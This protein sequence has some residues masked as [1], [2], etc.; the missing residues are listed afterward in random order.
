[1]SLRFAEMTF[2]NLAPSKTVLAKTCGTESCSKSGT[3]MRV[4]HDRSRALE[5]QT[6][7]QEKGE[8]LTTQIARD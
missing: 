1:M 8:L 7:E 6:R 5:A 3:L 4:E 2:S